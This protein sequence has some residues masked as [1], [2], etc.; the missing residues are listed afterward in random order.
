MPDWEKKIYSMPGAER[1]AEVALHQT[2]EKLPR[3]KAV[4]MVIQWDDGSY[5]CDWSCQKV[6]ELCMASMMLDIEARAIA[7]GSDGKES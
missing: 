2:I 1:T 6:S 7:T 5:S 3:I 4:S